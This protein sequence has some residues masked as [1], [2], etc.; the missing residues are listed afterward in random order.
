MK[1]TIAFITL[2][3]F[4]NL[5]VGYMAAILKENGFRVKILDVRSSKRHI[6]NKI[7]TSKPLVI[8]F[9]IV[10]HGCFK[11]FTGLITYIRSHCGDIHFTAG[12]HYAT[13]STDELFREVP[14]LDSIVRFEGE[15][16]MLELAKCL[17]SGS[18]WKSVAGIAYRGEDRIIKNAPGQLEKDLDKF[19]YP[20]RSSLRKFV[21]EM[22][23]ATLIAGRGCL[24]NCTFCNTRSFYNEAGGPVKRIRK[25]EMVAQE[26]SY[27]N[28][29]SKCFI[30]LFVDDDFPVNPH[31][32][33]DWVDNFCLELYKHQLSD[34]I[35]WK[36]CCR[37]DEVTESKFRLMKKH[38]LFSVFLGIEDGNDDGLKRLNKKITVQKIIEG[39][40]I[41]KKLKLNLD[42]GFMLFQPSTTFRSLNENFDFLINLFGDGYSPVTYLK[43]LPFYKTRVREQ[44]LEEGRLKEADGML[45]YDFIEPGMNEY[46]SFVMSCFRVWLRKPGSVHGLATLGNNYFLVFSK[47]FGSNA[48][49]VRLKYMLKKIISSSNV[50]IIN[51]MKQIAN[52]YESECYLSDPDVLNKHEKLIIEMESF[53]TREIYKVIDRLYNLAF[54]S[55]FFMMSNEKNSNRI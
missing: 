18:D 15:Y 31:N 46:Y 23:C 3:E 1:K 2:G 28:K 29:I 19:P 39:I 42:Y 7:L 10:Y 21:F 9:S 20:L 4:D 45:D 14:E 51:E 36:I 49:A 54:R 48:K 24:Y 30:F 6:I 25:P 8:G 50:F 41:L 40:A 34:K 22:P 12:G 16:P 13:L 26:I 52:V 5:G 17:E 37:P 27:L 32:R 47:Y 35:M 11:R 53:Y 33:I 38:G 44:L 43:L 55:L